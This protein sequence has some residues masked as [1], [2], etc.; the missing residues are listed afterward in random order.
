MSKKITIIM[1]GG[2]IHNVLV[3]GG[4]RG[5]V[6]EDDIDIR[7]IDYDVDTLEEDQITM[8]EQ[9]NGQELGAYVYRTPKQFVPDDEPMLNINP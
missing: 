6:V 2:V 1:D 4:K 7:V 9:G 8:V 3:G 5:D